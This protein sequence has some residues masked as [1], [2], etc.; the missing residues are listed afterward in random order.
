VDA[1]ARPIG[2][3]CFSPNASFAHRLPLPAD[4]PVHAR[5]ASARP[6]ELAPTALDTLGELMRDVKVKEIQA[7]PTGAR[8]GYQLAEAVQGPYRT[9]RRADFGAPRLVPPTL[10]GL[11]D[12]LAALAE[13]L[14]P[15]RTESR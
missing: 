9:S 1:V 2:T 11:L 12:G 10:A 5:I 6:T 13:T 15:E 3:E 4:F 7:G 8:I 14:T